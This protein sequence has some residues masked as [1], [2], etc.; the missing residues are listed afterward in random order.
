M[1]VLSKEQQEDYAKHAQEFITSHTLAMFNDGNEFHTGHMEYQAPNSTLNDIENRLALAHTAQN[2]IRASDIPRERMEEIGINQ[3]VKNFQ[4]DLIQL[5]VFLYGDFSQLNRFVH[6]KHAGQ[7]VK[8][9]ARAEAFLAI[10]EFLTLCPIVCFGVSKKV[11]TLGFESS[12]AIHARSSESELRHVIQEMTLL[13]E[14]GHETMGLCT[15][16]S[17]R[18]TRYVTLWPIPNTYR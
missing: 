6:Q 2:K 14:K 9:L 18:E 4:L 5:S 11:L 12:N 7:L 3:D 16:T 17:M 1:A 10:C 13:T 8:Y 15:E